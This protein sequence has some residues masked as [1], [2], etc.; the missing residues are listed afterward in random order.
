[1][2][3]RM[4]LFVLGRIL[5]AEAFFMLLPLITSIIYGENLIPFLIPIAL[6]AAL[7]CVLTLRPPKSRLMRARD[8]FVC[9]GLS[10]IMLSLFGCLPFIISGAIPS[11][12]DAFFE[13]VSGFTT[14]GSSVLSNPEVLD[15]GLLFWRSFTHWIGGMGILVFVLAIMP[16]G[17]TKSSG[18]MH[19]M[20][21][22]APG[23]S[24][25]KVV[26]KI[27]ETSR[28]MYGIYIVMTFILLGLLLIGKMPIFDA[29]CHTFGTAGTGGFGIK[30][31]S[32]A[33]YSPYCQYVLATFMVLFGINF[34]VYYLLIV[35]KVFKALCS[36]ELR[37]Y[38]IIIAVAVGSITFSIYGFYNA[39]DSV[40]CTAEEAF[41]MSYFQVASI[42]STSGF[43]TVNYNL[44]PTVTHAI[45][46]ILTFI[47]GSAG[48]T[49]GGIKVSR[50][51]LLFKN[52][53]REIRYILNP[54]TIKSVKFDGKTIDH[55]Q[56]RGTTSFIIVYILIFVASTLSVIAIESCDLVTGFTSVATCLN[57]VGP[58]LS[59]VG[60]A[61]NF[62]WMKD[63]TKLLLSFNMLAGRLEIFPLLILFSPSTWK[64]FS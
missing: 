59:L 42:I 25:D 16:K 50:I 47:G 33:S 56:I 23:P 11:F 8:S 10:W 49:G 37:W 14:T 28:I 12:F 30:A 58:G 44:W 19:L 22:E 15:R 17:D 45:I 29:L 64:K 34:N 24:V 13:T 62:G 52:G 63:I 43:S 38:L 18:L 41:R 20:R 60:P 35:G 48:C 2:N 31:D 4:L 61:S 3:Y 7:G 54:R 55:E 26:P 5:S 6:L 1:M 39:P 32:V 36:E 51:I 27:A 53:I 9:V 21:A 57:N 40:G 46:I